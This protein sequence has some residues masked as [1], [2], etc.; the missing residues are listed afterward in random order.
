MRNLEALFQVEYGSTVGSLANLPRDPEARA[1]IIRAVQ[2]GVHAARRALVE[3]RRRKAP[4]FF[5][6]TGK[7]GTFTVRSHS[8][9]SLENLPEQLLGWFT[10]GRV[11]RTEPIFAS[12]G[13]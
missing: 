1:R 4:I 7:P 13:S 11:S 6:S 9:G 10:R 3:G 8:R 5:A 12:D 2:H